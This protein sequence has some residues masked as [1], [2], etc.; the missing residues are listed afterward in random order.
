MKKNYPKSLEDVSTK[1][2]AMLLNVDLV[3]FE[4]LK[5][6]EA[7]VTGDAAVIG[8]KYNGRLTGPASIVLKYAKSV[9]ASRELAKGASMYA[10]PHLTRGRN[11]RGAGYDARTQPVKEGA[12]LPDRF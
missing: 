9:D 3:G 5:K 7:G 2:L 6:L 4:I 1:W 12:P 8:L 10:P 11:S